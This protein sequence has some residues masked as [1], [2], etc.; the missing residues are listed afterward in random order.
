MTDENV[1]Q[2]ISKC[3]DGEISPAEQEHLDEILLRDGAARELLRDMQSLH[4]SAR[5]A[6]ENTLG[7]DKVAPAAVLFQRALDLHDGPQ[8]RLALP[9]WVRVGATLAAGFLLGVAVLVIARQLASQPGPPE[10]D[11]PAGGTIAVAPEIAPPPDQPD[12]T[13]DQGPIIRRLDPSRPD[14]WAR[15]PVDWYSLKDQ[16]GSEWLIAAPRDDNVR[17]VSYYGE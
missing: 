16:Q 4:R 11:S 15:R 13:T 3:L 1:E 2:L 17:S 5:E 14:R 12:P 9:H 7:P 6:L 10:H 8:R